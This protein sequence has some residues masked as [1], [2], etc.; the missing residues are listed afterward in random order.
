[1]SR[2]KHHHTVSAG[3]T[4]SFRPVQDVGANNLFGLPHGESEGGCEPFHELA[5]LVVIVHF[6]GD[7]KPE[8]VNDVGQAGDEP[9]LCGVV[10]NRTALCFDRRKAKHRSANVFFIRLVGSGLV[11]YLRELLRVLV[12]FIPVNLFD[13]GPEQFGKTAGS[14]NSR[15]GQS[16]LNVNGCAA[17][18]AVLCDHYFPTS[19]CAEGVINT[20]D[21]AHNAK[22]SGSVG[23]RIGTI[24]LHTR[25]A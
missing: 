10:G 1:M 22:L 13:S 14:H 11:E 15:H 12:V 21:K 8:G 2:G 25:S 17:V 18:V 4:G 23:R 19:V 24:D 7:D 5:I 9:L 16:S 20:R 3:I 6:A